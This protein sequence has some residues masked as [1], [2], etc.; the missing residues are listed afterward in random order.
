MR[1]AEGISR[2]EYAHRFGRVLED[3]LP[4]IDELIAEGFLLDDGERICF[5]DEGFLVSNE[6]I[7]RMLP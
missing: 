3:D 6:I 1:L 4:P 7:A 5:T 2:G